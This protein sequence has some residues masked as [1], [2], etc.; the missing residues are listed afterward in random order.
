MALNLR[1]NDCSSNVNPT[2]YKSMVGSFMYLTATRPSI[3]Y[4]VSLVSRFME[5][6][7]ETHWQATKRILRYVN[8]TKEYGI[9]YTVT[10]DFRLVGYTY[11]DCE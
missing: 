9:L 10:N 4:A 8:G 11:S 3:L 7:K 5:K 2:L 1:K 6:P